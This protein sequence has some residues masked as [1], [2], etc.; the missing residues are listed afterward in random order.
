MQGAI[1]NLICRFSTTFCTLAVG[2]GIAL[3][4]ASP[5]FGQETLQVVDP[6]IVVVLREISPAQIQTDIEKLVSVGTPSTLSAQDP[7][8]IAAGCGIESARAWLKSQFERD[9]KTTS[10]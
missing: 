2:I 10:G 3:I 6:R 1:I 9:S 4:F 7:A 8:S 5:D